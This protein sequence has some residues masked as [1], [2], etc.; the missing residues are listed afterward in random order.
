MFQLFFYRGDNAN[1]KIKFKKF[2]RGDWAE[3]K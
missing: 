1:E 3:V 2:G